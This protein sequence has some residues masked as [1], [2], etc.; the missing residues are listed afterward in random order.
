LLPQ[1]G[2]RLIQAFAK[3]APSNAVPLDQVIV[4]AGRRPP[5]LM[6]PDRPVRYYVQN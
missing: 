3:N 1:S 2:Q 4:E 5:S 6:L